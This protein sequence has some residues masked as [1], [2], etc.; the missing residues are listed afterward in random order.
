VT[1]RTGHDFARLAMVNVAQ[2]AVAL[3]LVV[4]VALLS[5]YGLCLRAVISAAI[6]AMMLHYWR[7]VRVGPKWNFAHWKHLLTIGLPIF[8][9]GQ[10]Y[11]WWGVLDQTLVLCYTGKAGMGLYAMVVMAIATLEQLPIAV[12]QVV[13]PRMAEQFGRT[14]RFDG[15]L[16]M[17]VKPMFLT[18]AAM[19]LAIVAG[20]WLVEPLT[21][22]LVPKYV[23]AVP[24]VRWGLL[25]P[26]VGSFGPINNVFNVVRRQD[27]YLAATLA[28]I[29]VYLVTLLWLVRQQAELTAFPQAMLVGRV[30]YVGACCAFI[31]YI[32]RKQRRADAPLP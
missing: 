16:G 31:A 3:A 17:T 23:D 8:G 2:N 32:A 20:W 1:Y 15:L 19:A 9:V 22:I 7:P 24:A 18:A 25:V 10:L 4:L 27:L 14:G 30:A 26:F 11:A 28:G 6:G 29:G 5:F 13:Y 21:R 12:T